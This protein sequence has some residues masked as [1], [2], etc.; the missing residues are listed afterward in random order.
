MDADEAE[1]LCD[2]LAG[3]ASKGPSKDPRA[4]VEA[5]AILRKITQSPQATTH[6][7][8][9]ANLVDRALRGW[10]DTEERFQPLLKSHSS[11]IYALIDRLHSALREASRF[12][13]RRV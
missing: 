4:L 11:E 9:R 8:D 13:P 6:L 10:F 2:V 1:R 5:T 7:R 3:L 12:K